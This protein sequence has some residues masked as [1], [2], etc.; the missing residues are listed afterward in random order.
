MLDGFQGCWM[1][2]GWVLDRC[3]MVFQGAG[4]V[5]DAFIGCW[6]GAGWFLRVLDG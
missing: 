2:A 6:M 4:W 3:W 1:G 5:L